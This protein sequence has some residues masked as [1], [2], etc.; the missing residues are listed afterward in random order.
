ML[1]WP[2]ASSIQ[3][4]FARGGI[5]EIDL[6]GRMRVAWNALLLCAPNVET[7]F[8][9]V[10]TQLFGPVVDP[11]EVI[12]GFA[13]RATAPVH[14]DAV[15][16]VET[17]VAID[18][19]SGHA[20]GFQRS[21]VKSGQTGVSRG[22]ATYAERLRADA[23]TIKAKARI[24]DQRG[25]EPVIEADREALVAVERMAREAKSGRTAG[26]VAER[27]GG[28]NVEIGDS[29]AAED[30]GRR[31][32]V[33]VHAAVVL[34]AVKVLAADETK[35]LKMSLPKFGSGRLPR[36]FAIGRGD[37]NDVDLSVFAKTWRPAPVS[38]RR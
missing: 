6:A 5:V 30:M 38:G 12:F 36:S 20:A 31:A 23:I 22:R 10:V 28:E 11:L 33:I 14:A 16:E 34:I 32:D 15:T 7:E 3:V 35:L 29:V 26:H 4:G 24:R 37:R 13:R 9:G 21:G 19:K 2:A 8:D 1:A 17:A 27:G 25:S 18:V